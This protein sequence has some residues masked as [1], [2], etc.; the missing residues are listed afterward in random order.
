MATYKTIGDRLTIC[1][2]LLVM[3]WL[4]IEFN[5]VMKRSDWT[6]RLGH[7]REVLLADRQLVEGEEVERVAHL[8][9]K[10]YTE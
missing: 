4:R 1:V 5:G 2:A 9:G 8:E 10:Q 6:G 3:D 7:P